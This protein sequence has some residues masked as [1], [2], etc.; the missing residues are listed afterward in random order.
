MEGGGGERI[1]LKVIRCIPIIEDILR[2][3]CSC[4]NFVAY[5]VVGTKII[6]S[7]EDVKIGIGMREAA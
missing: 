4:S 2:I 6:S 3:E 1:K 5:S 7:S